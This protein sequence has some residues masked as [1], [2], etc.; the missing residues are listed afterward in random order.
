MTRRQDRSGSGRLRHS[1]RRADLTAVPEVRRAVRDLVRQWGAPGSADVAELLVSE[2]VTNA[3]LHTDD[4]AVVTATVA[5]AR[6]RVEVRDFTPG[7]PEPRK[8]EPDASDDCT[9]GRG[10]VL[11]QSLAD[12]W[13]VRAQE[14]GKVVWFELDGGQA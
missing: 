13:G 10:L 12:A 1:V 9:H 8:P 4:G 5:P 3:L 6:L 11:V 7:V 14:A 2:L